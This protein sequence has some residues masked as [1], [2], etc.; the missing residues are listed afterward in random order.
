MLKLA[1]GEFVIQDVKFDLLNK[2]ESKLSNLDK[3][4]CVS[5]FCLSIPLLSTTIGIVVVEKIYLEIER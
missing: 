2:I 1:V 4:S 3:P 5:A